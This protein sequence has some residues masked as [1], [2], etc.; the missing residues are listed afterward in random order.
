VVRIVLDTDVV[1]LHRA[2]RL[3]VSVGRHVIEHEVCIAFATAGELW[4][5]ALA[6]TGRAKGKPLAATLPAP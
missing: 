2:G 1:S 6:V 3:P 5:G 4:K